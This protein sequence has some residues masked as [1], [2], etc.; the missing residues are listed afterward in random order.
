MVE[1]ILHYQ[2]LTLKADAI[3][4]T[5]LYV[6]EY[7]IQSSVYPKEKIYQLIKLQADTIKKFHSPEVC[8]K[9]RVL[10]V[11]SWSNLILA[12]T[13]TVWF[14][15]GADTN[16]MIWYWRWH[17]PYDFGDNIDCPVSIFESP[18]GN[19]SSIT[20]D[21]SDIRWVHNIHCLFTAIC[22]GK[23]TQYARRA[24][25]SRS[26]WTKRIWCFIAYLL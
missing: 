10:I 1:R 4:S 14:G 16:R 22:S 21:V 15:T 6:R 5:Q 11:L 18:E 12:L 17:K 24:L 19:C 8:K 20:A 25:L 7:R 9:F 3:S 13:Q 2:L 26:L 23:W